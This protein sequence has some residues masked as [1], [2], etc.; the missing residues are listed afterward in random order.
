MRTTAKTLG[1][2]SRSSAML[3]WLLGISVLGCSPR[4]PP[5]KPCPEPDGGQVFACGD[6]QC[7]ANQLCVVPGGCGQEP[8]VT[9]PGAHC[10]DLPA[11]CTDRR[12]QCSCQA[13]IARGGDG[14]AHDGEALQCCFFAGW[15]PGSFDVCTYGCA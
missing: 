13:D 4:C 12:T 2:V 10:I 1:G 15:Q 9:S 5:E 8:T 7:N 14:G 6:T 11:V 3:A